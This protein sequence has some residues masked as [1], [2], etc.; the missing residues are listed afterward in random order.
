MHPEESSG[1]RSAKNTRP[2]GE[3][4]K[5]IIDCVNPW[6]QPG[7]GKSIHVK[8]DCGA[9]MLFSHKS[10]KVYWERRI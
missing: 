1:P 5:A 4:T 6:C 9:V 2:R 10:A 3:T 7:A 8:K